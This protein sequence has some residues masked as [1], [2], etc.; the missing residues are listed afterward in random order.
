M[1]A[2]KFAAFSLAC[3]VCL[4]LL[5]YLFSVDREHVER[6]WFGMLM[7][8]IASKGGGEKKAKKKKAPQLWRITQPDR[9]IVYS[10]TVWCENKD[11]SR[12]ETCL[13][14]RSMAAPS[15]PPLF[16]SRRSHLIRANPDPNPWVAVRIVWQDWSTWACRCKRGRK[17]AWQ[18]AQWWISVCVPRVHLQNCCYKSQLGELRRCPG[19][20][21]AQ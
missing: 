5:I 4:F 12:D 16:F 17:S 6:L 7:K 11:D 18:G 2:G 19:S 3:F 10:K 1:A 8:K 14:L 21:A 15:H 9:E 20:D 13:C